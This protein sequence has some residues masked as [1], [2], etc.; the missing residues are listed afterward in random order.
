MLLFTSGYKEEVSTVSDT[1]FVCRGLLAYRSSSSSARRTI[2]AEK[3]KPYKLVSKKRA[4]RKRC[5]LVVR[6]IS[7]R[8]SQPLI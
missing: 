1:R 8:R 6:R 7:R 4:A 3:Q 2:R 5:A